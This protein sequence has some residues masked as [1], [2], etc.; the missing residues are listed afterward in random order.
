MTLSETVEVSGHAPVISGKTGGRAVVDGR[1]VVMFASND[2]LGLASH[3]Y[4]LRRARAALDEYGMG[5]GMNP[6]R[7]L[8]RVHYELIEELTRF[9]GSEDV[10][11]FNSC[12]AANCGLIATLVGHDDSVFSDELNHASIIDG[13]RLSRART[14][15]YPHSDIKALRMKLGDPVHTGA[16]LVVSDG[17]FSMEAEVVELRSILELAASRSATVVI[18]ESHS[19][20]ILGRTGRGSAELLGVDPRSF[21]QTGT[22]SKA[23]GAGIGGY[24]AARSGVT[25]QLRTSARFYVFISPMPAASAAAALAALEVIQAEPERIELAKERARRLRRGLAQLG[26]RV[27]GGDHHPSVPVLIGDTDRTRRISTALRGRGIFAPAVVFPVVPE[28]QARIRLQVS[29]SHSDQDLT[30]T[31]LA[32]EQERR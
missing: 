9:I 3:P 4:V 8:T 13:C 21:I 32:F 7:A 27:L 30:Q 26:F 24:V 16:R 25:A 5:T 14:V 23:L 2:Y 22:F 28:G 20:G 17:V 1:E 15:V 10:V 18:D 31:L 11:L 29:A 19:V 12:T 6:G